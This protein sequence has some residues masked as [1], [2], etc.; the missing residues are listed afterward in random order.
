MVWQETAK[1]KYSFPSY[2]IVHFYPSILGRLLDRAQS[3]ASDLTTI[4]DGG[5]LTIIH[6]RKSILFS[7]GKIWTQKDSNSLFD[8]SM[9]SFDGA[10][11]CELVGLFILKRLEENLANK[12]LP[13]TGTT[14]WLL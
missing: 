3:W 11:I 9:G 7:D 2:D 14:N 12:M 6:A 10:A 8:V 5:I 4:T 13:F 1:H